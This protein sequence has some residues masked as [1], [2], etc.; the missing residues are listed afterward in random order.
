MIGWLGWEKPEK[1]A[2]AS[3]ATVDR[4]DCCS[5]QGYNSAV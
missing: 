1:A 2:P 3:P 5:P 4:F